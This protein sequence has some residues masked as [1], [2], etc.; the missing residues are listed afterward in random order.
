MSGSAEGQGTLDVLTINR[1]DQLKA[2]GHP[3]RLRVLEM[4]GEEA[5]QAFTNREM[6]S[7]IGI[8]PGHLHFHVRMLLKAGLIQLADENGGRREKPYRAVARN[9]T[10]A[11][12][13]LSANTVISDVHS[14]LLEEVQR[15]L[16]KYSQTGLFRVL[17]DAV[18]IDPER[19]SDLIDQ[20]LKQAQSE[21][22]PELE[23]VVLTVFMHPPATLG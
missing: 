21:Y 19:L 20:A 11:P 12:E 8:D 14:S 3:L 18:R 17:T 22:D 10:V 23:P 7:R 9:I 1:P 2:L 6:A 15:G 16:A 13:L 4:L 5:G